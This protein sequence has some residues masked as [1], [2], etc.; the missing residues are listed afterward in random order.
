LFTEGEE[1]GRKAIATMKSTLYK[2]GKPIV[3]D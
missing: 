3:Q 1:C 2:T